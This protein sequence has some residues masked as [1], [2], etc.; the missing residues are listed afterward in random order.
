VAFLRFARDKRGYEHFY[1]VHSTTRRGKSRSRILYWF[2]S[3][4]GVKVGRPPFDESMRRAL[5]AQYPEIAFDWQ[6][7]IDTP[8]P[9]PTPDVERW[10]ERRRLERAAKQAAVAE[11][12]AES[13]ETASETAESSEPA[14][15]EETRPTAAAA[16]D[17]AGAEPTVKRRRR[18]GGRRGRSSSG[19]PVDAAAAARGQE[20]APPPIGESTSAPAI[21]DSSDRGEE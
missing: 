2:R 6:Q 4:P 15:A 17:A 18:R 16:T 3:P 7:L 8:I 1:L 12:A 21:A 14:V 10:R 5:E 9:P 13:P 19:A 11:A 20:S